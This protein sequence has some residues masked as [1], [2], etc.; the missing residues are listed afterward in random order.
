VQASAYN[1]AVLSS[2]PA[3]YWTFDEPS[4]NAIDQVAGLPGDELVAGT[5]ATRGPSTNTAGGVSLGTAAKSGPATYSV[6]GKQYIVQALGGLPGFGRDEAWAAEFG[7][8]IVAF[9]L[10]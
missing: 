9:T 5:V 7:S 8:L 2:G 10:D 4:G 6:N 1:A 3:F